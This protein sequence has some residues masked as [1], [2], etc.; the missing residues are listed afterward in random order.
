MPKQLILLAGLH[1]TAT[2]SIQKTCEANQ[3]ILHKAGLAFWATRPSLQ[4]DS[5]P[6]EIDDGAGQTN[7]TLLLSAAFK[8]RMDRSGLVGQ[9]NWSAKR[10][11]DSRDAHRS[12]FASV[13]EGA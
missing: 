8:R 10:P 12:R 9:L 11:I 2:T 13:L 6:A 5:A 4:P 1:K 3:A 7:H